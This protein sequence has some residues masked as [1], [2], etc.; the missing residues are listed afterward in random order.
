LNVTRAI[1]TAIGR[2]AEQEPELG[3]VLRT[4]IRTGSSC[5]YEP[6]PGVPLLWRV[7]R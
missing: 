2:I 6:D 3:H 4:A 7:R 1:R 5:V